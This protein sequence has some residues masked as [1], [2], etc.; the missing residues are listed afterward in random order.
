MYRIFFK[1]YIKGQIKIGRVV[2]IKK[3]ESSTN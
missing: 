1:S 3:E 2:I